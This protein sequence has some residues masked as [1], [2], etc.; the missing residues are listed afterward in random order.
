MTPLQPAQ[1]LHQIPFHPHPLP[2]TCPQ[3]PLSPI[4]PLSH[5][6]AFWISGPIWH[7][8]KKSKPYN[9][10][11]SFQLWLCPLLLFSWSQSWWASSATRNAGLKPGSH[12]LQQTLH[13][14]VQMWAG[15]LTR[16]SYTLKCPLKFQRYRWWRHRTM[17]VLVAEILGNTI[18]NLY[19][20][21]S[22]LGHNF[23]V[24]IP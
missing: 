21:H 13:L 14:R 15:V 22:V 2:L 10:L 24:V 3:H 17:R 6:L 12:Q 19:G 16:K 18:I 8:T 23:N 5:P 1:V 9:C 7:N 11:W 20:Q 4:H